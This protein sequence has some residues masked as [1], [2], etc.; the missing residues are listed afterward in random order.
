MAAQKIAYLL[1]IQTHTHIDEQQ[2]GRKA[3]RLKT[4]FM[5]FIY[6]DLRKNYNAISHHYYSQFTLHILAGPVYYFFVEKGRYR[7]KCKALSASQIDCMLPFIS[8]HLTT[9][10]LHSIHTMQHLKKLNSIQRNKINFR[11]IS[12]TSAKRKK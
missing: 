4:S 11:M 9:A 1:I 2:V 7:Q 6:V 12:Y 8:I 3:L 10:H 5:V